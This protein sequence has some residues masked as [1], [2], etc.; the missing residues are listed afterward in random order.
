MKQIIED[1]NFV[2]KNDLE[3]HNEVEQALKTAPEGSLEIWKRKK[4]L[5]FYKYSNDKKIEY[6]NRNQE[7]IYSL[8]QKR[9]NLNVLK[10]LAKRISILKK[11]IELLTS[12][13]SLPTPWQLYE[14]EPQEIK[15]YLTPHHN[16]DES[17][18]KR[19]QAIKFCHKKIDDYTYKSVR[20]EF[21]RSKTELIIAD[22]LYA[23]GIPYHYEVA[24]KVN[25]GCIY[26]DFY[27]LN[28][29]TRKIYVWEHFGRMDD[30]TYCKKALL[31]LEAYESIGYYEGKN[32]ILTYE[33][34][35]YHINTSNIDKVIETYFK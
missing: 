28:K 21:V 11:C 35:Q 17:Y 29:R 5:L 26:P 27:V 14:Q 22:K 16:S 6:I 10:T 7:E 20:G 24:M 12:L 25:F 18:A 23:A 19:W 31:K 2:L 34:S 30:P 33:S 15:K 3:L 13:M 1:L 32:L 8:I 4:K 9:H